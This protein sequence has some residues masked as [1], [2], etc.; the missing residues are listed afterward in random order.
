MNKT[1]YFLG[2]SKRTLF[3]IHHDSKYFN[4]KKSYKQFIRRNKLK[5]VIELAFET[6]SYS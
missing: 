4:S 6:P 1:I 2:Y 3:G 5:I